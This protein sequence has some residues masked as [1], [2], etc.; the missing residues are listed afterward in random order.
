MASSSAPDDLLARARAAGVA[1]SYVDWAGRT[2]EVDRDAVEAVLA[3]RGT[4]PARTA[5]TDRG[6]T[7]ALPLPPRC[8]GW[9]VQLYAVHSAGSWG[10]GDLADLRELAVRSAQEFGADLVLVNPLHAVAPAHP[11]TASPYSPTSRRYVNPIYLHLEDLPEYAA[12]SPETRRAIDQLRPAATDVDAHIDR[13][14]VWDAKIAALQLLWPSARAV[15]PS[16]DLRDF[17]TFCAL[18]EVH[19][20]PWQQWP[21][22]L[23][24]PDGEAV[25]AAREKLADRIAFHAWLQVCCDEQL[26]EVQ[27]SATNAGMR[28]GIVHDLAV[29]VD[30]GGADAW[31]LQDVLAGEVTVGAPPD[32]FNQHGQ[33]WA[34]PPWRPDVL[35]DQGFHPYRAMLESVL[36]HGGG[37]R[38]DHVMGL[39]RLWWVPPG[40]TPDGGTYVSYDEDALLGLLAEAAAER[41]ALVV[42]E[43]LGTVEPSMRDALERHGILGSALLWFERTDDDPNGPPKPPE[44]WREAAMASISTHDLPTAHGLFAAEHVRVR[45]ELGQLRRPIE[46]EQTQADVEREALLTS[47][48]AEGLLA[49]ADRHDPDA[50]T[51]A[52]HGLLARTPC[53]VLLASPYDVLGELRQPNLPG[54]TDAYPN[55][56]IPLPV[57]LEELLTDPRT[58]AT[59][60][61]LGAR[62]AV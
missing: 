41:G 61:V 55:W 39:S 32:S 10:I 9:S 27:A 18:A 43:D 53:R 40:A 13:D 57:T 4:R 38:V 8:W 36:G 47:L 17:A 56:R 50:V 30:P 58:A 25:V 12:A 3:Q 42:G 19:G 37:I 48:E 45:A 35:A 2:V 54:T 21:A 15:E 52:M 34:L 26:H 5:P 31:A 22:E 1:V 23:H 6:A 7:R 49:R 14:A 16:E 46:E 28:V 33:D 24:R 62:P 44:Q 60:A 51:L 29:G 20:T 11:I 59:A